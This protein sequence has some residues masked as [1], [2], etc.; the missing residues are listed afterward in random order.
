MIWIVSVV[1]IAIIIA[2]CWKVGGMMMKEGDKTA[3]EDAK[4]A[5]IVLKV[6][7]GILLIVAVL[8][9]AFASIKQVPAGHVGLVYTFNNITGQRDAGI[10]LVA[11]WQGFK[12]ADVRIQK[13]RPA[14]TCFDGQIEEC[15]EAFSKETQDVFIVA[16]VNLSVNKGDVQDL[17]RNVG[18]DYL[19]KIVRPRVLQIFKDETVKYTSVEIAPNR[20]TI[21]AVVRERLSKELA[22][23]SITVN[24]LLIDNFDFRPE[25]KQAIEAK[26]IATQE[27]L[28]Q[29]ELVAAEAAKAR[30]V[31]ATALGAAEKLRIEAQ[32]QADANR[33]IAES[34]SPQLIQWQAIQRLA[35]NVEIALIPSGNGIIIDPAALLGRATP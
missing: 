13:V 34:I 17:Y 24:D 6:V 5:G 35:G 15:L 16:T 30:Q 27:A 7:A 3:E 21:R 23:Y 10:Q 20:E 19:E 4:I 9:T 25:F 11:P 12:L 2:A 31:A 22:P 1:V 29:Q 26:Q 28:K 14:T 18:S 33:L 8:G 32:G